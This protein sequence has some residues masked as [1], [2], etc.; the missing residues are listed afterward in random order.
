MHGPRT[1]EQVGLHLVLL[2]EHYVTYDGTR[3]SRC[4]DVN[5]TEH[6]LSTPHAPPSAWEPP[7]LP[8]PNL[9]KHI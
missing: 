9:T 1:L 6:V 8:G 4:K 3:Q 5:L 7:S 2:F